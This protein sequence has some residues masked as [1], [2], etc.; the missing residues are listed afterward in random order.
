[1]STGRAEDALRPR[2]HRVHRLYWRIWFAILVTVALF[3]VLA[4]TAWR[5]IGERPGPP[6]IEPP[7]L[8]PS[9]RDH[10]SHELAPLAR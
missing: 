8:V 5:L 4:V 10:P 1:M 6:N 3:A 9:R 7:N 2:G